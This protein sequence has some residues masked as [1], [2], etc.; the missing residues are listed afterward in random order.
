VVISSL[1]VSKGVRAGIEGVNG[2]MAV[3]SADKESCSGVGSAGSRAC[4]ANGKNADRNWGFE[5][6]EMTVVCALI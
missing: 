4:T 3:L 6:D 2:E 5:S 1:L